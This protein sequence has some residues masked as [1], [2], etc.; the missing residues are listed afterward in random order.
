MSFMRTSTRRNSAR[1]I[2]EE[3]A[4]RRNLGNIVLPE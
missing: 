4:S 2:S 1:A 3:I